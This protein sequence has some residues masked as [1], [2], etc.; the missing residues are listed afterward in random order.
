M[1]EQ[2]SINDLRQYVEKLN[3]EMD[4]CLMRGDLQG[5]ANFYSDDATIIG[6]EKRKIQG[7]EEI[8][9]FCFAMT[10]VKEAKAVVLD[11]WM[12]GDF[13]CQVATSLAKWERNGEEGSYFCDCMYVWRK[14]A[15]G[16]YR[17]FLDAY[18]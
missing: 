4:D 6:F 16:T 3:Q 11:V 17:I 2:N 18:N 15:D 10:G 14:E 9:E 1:S 13:I 12:S 5:Y 7:R 8:N